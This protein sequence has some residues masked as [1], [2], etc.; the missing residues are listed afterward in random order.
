MKVI[1]F[2]LVICLMIL[3]V[4]GF[5][6]LRLGSVEGAIECV[7]D[8]VGI[9]EL[10]FSASPKPSGTYYWGNNSLEFRSDGTVISTFMG[11]QEKGEFSVDGS[12]ITYSGGGIDTVGTYDSTNDTVTFAG[13]LYTKN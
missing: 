6:A 7:A 13:Q 2:L 4:I 10:S 5:E 1:K 9:S 11:L 3:S 12:E 8:T